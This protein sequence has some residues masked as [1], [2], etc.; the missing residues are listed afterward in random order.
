MVLGIGDDMAMLRSEGQPVLVTSD[1]LLDGVHFQSEKHS[2]SEIGRKAA[3]CSLSDCAAMAVKPVGAI[4]SLALPRS[5]SAG[6]TQELVESLIT[7]CEEFGCP[8]VGGDTT[9]WDNPLAIDMAML[10]QPY[11][12]IVPVRRDGGRD[13]DGIFVTG[14]LG[15]SLLGRH[16]T[17]TPRVVEAE[18]IARTLGP[19]LHAMMDI[20]DGVAIDLDRMVEASG[21]GAFL[22][23]ELLQR[24]AS[25]AAKEASGNDGRSILDHVLSDGEDFELLIA[26]DIDADAA[27]NL[28]L[29][30]IGKITAGSG[31]RIKTS[32]GNEE[33]LEPRGYQHL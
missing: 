2:P 14:K 15:G 13:G 19:R 11:A 33:K 9:S 12:D 3:C 26:G 27:G 28:G 32:A 23:E 22:E 1:M 29:L 18:R 31:L 4:L 10:A 16:L 17:F 24:A 30:P 7:T 6:Q 5:F 25:D 8:L 21:V 20:S